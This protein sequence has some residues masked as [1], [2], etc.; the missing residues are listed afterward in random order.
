MEKINTFFSLFSTEA[1]IVIILVAYFL[2]AYL[3]YKLYRF[4]IGAIQLMIGAYQIWRDG[5]WSELWQ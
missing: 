5:E 1:S 4:I 3:L 2:S